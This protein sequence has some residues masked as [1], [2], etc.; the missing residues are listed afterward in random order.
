MSK[1]HAKNEAGRL[2]LDIS[3]FFL[4]RFVFDKSKWLAPLVSRY[5]GSPQLG[6][7]I[8]TNCITKFQNV[9]PNVCS[10]NF[11]F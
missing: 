8:K 7:N 6:H 2:V 9:N 1:N 10:I 5:F 3:L 4:K 11:D